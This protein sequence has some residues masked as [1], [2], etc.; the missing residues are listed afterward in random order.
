MG[1]VKIYEGWLSDHFCYQTV[2][3]LALA[4]SRGV[5]VHIPLVQHIAFFV[6]SILWVIQC[7]FLHLAGEGTY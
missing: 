1:V 6:F 4:S 3:F 7:V 5:S 2:F